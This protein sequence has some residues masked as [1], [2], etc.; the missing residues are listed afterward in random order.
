MSEHD[1]K[2]CNCLSCALNGFLK[3]ILKD[4]DVLISVED[5]ARTMPEAYDLRDAFKERVGPL[6]DQLHATCKELNLPFSA[7]FSVRQEEDGD[8]MIA[9]AQYLGEIARVPASLLMVARPEEDC[10]PKS[11]GSLARLVGLD[12]ERQVRI[13]YKKDKPSPVP[14]TDP[15]KPAKTARPPVDTTPAETAPVTGSDTLQ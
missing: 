2:D 13:A 10:T 4:K 6:L 14:P 5:W 7:R 8:G 15:V 3:K 9:T 12:A 1:D 11:L